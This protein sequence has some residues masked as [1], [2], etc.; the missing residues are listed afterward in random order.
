MKTLTRKGY[1]RIYV[2]DPDHIYRVKEIIKE[3]D[4]FEREYLPKDLIAPWSEYPHL[5]Y[6]HKFDGLCMNLLTAHCWR[7]G[8]MTLRQWYAGQAMQGLAPKLEMGHY[9]VS[10]AVKDAFEVADA[11]IA[12]EKAEQE[13]KS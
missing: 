9:C 4:A 2:D 5:S 1:G 6:T 7:E 12:H 3:L 11:M 8:G 13:E 10:D